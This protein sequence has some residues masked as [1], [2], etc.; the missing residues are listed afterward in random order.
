MKVLHKRD[1]SIE[2]QE[3]SATDRQERI[4]GWH[5]EYVNDGRVLLLGAGALGNE[6]AKNLALMGLGYLFVADMDHITTSNLSRAV[7]FRKED[8]QEQRA[9]ADVVAQRSQS[10]NVNEHAVVQTFRGD[11]VWRLGGGVFR[12]VDVVLGCL[13]NVEAR[14]RANTR[15]LLTNTPFLDGGILGLA[16]TVTAV[17]PPATACWECTTTAR[18]RAH[19][20]SRYDSCSQVMLREIASGKLPT[21]Q[22]ASSITAGFQ[23]LEA[24]KVLQGLPW[25]AGHIIQFD[26]GA[27]QIDLDVLAI[28]RR[29]GCWCH[30]AQP[31]KDVLELPLSAQHHSLQDLLTSLHEHGYSDPQVGLAAPFIVMRSCISCH[32]QE[33][34]MQPR[35]LLTTEA[36]RCTYCGAEGNEWIRLLSVDSTHLKNFE[37]ADIENA[38]AMHE[39]MLALSLAA[40]GFPA[41]AL[42]P[43]S[44]GDT[45]DFEHMVAELTADAV[46]VMG[47]EAYATVRERD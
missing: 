28:S 47:G 37:K 12:R 40:V 17:H 21:V 25:S 32:R 45:W 16:G 31:I 18:E 13:D 29:P 41:L 6:A 22:V 1:F 7:F 35:F 46:A 10:L 24:I 34:V 19:A 43:F 38:P 3:E 4:Q 14:M 44:D 27:P 20:S 2:Q 30:Q 15:C 39:Q 26:A 5:Q 8:V 23:T 9:K 33:P 36:L 11:I 42:I